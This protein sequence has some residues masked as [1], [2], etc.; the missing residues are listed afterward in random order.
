MYITATRQPIVHDSCVLHF[1]MHIRT[2]H[3]HS[4]TNVKG[5]LGGSGEGN[6]AKQ[7]L[8]DLTVLVLASDDVDCLS[9]T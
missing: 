5:F 1:P 9:R 4:G 7:E 2:N 6:M 3:D 8:T